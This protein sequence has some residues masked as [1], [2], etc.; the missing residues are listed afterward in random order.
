VGVNLNQIAHRMNE[1]R[2]PPPDDLAEVL[3][4]IRSIMR[5]TRAAL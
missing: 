4:E 5:Q 2:L 3:A 1:L